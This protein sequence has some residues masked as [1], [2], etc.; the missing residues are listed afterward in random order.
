MKK[1]I[2]IITLSLVLVAAIGFFL[3][4]NNDAGGEGGPRE[5]NF[6]G[7]FSGGNRGSNSGG[8]SSQGEGGGENVEGN[9]L[10]Q[11][12]SSG[13]LLQQLTN[14]SIAGAMATS[15]TLPNTTVKNVVV[16]YVDRATGNIFE[17]DPTSLSQKRLTNT[18]IPGIREVLW[19]ESGE[20]LIMR[21][22]TNTD[23]IKSIAATI[24]DSFEEGGERIHELEVTFMDDDILYVTSSNKG[25]KILYLSQSRGGGVVGLSANFDS[26]N[27]EIVLESPHSEWIP[28]WLTSTLSLT[29]KASGVTSGFLY[30]V[31]TNGDFE[32]IIGN[33]LG[34]TTNT[35]QSGD[36][37]LYSESVQGVIKLSVLDVDSRN[38][39]A[40]SLATLP[41]KCVWSSQVASIIYCGVPIV[42]QSTTYPDEWYQ[43]VV[44]FSDEIWEIDVARD[45]TRLLISPVNTVQREI[46]VI[47]PFL[48]PNEE[49]LFFTNKKDSTLWSLRLN[50]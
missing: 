23:I 19:H 12:T 18:T 41:E 7:L 29:S 27:R 45:T 36:T 3:L 44:S 21:Y 5:G 28:Q 47:N 30:F 43:G 11:G 34:L 48:G 33:V 14:T 24:G 35:S 2:I 8:G 26:S 20:Q 4:F 38:T 17:I 50:K 1:I 39:Q 9:N 13:V 10:T 6:F 37:V 40:L 16:R 15:T 25:D 31:N 42:I 46:D 22:L 49:F 32:K